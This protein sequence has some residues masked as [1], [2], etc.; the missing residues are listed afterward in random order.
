MSIIKSNYIYKIYWRQLYTN[1]ADVEK[2]CIYIGDESIHYNSNINNI[3]KIE[4]N[5]FPLIKWIT[6]QFFIFRERNLKNADEKKMSIFLEASKG[7]ISP[8][9]SSFVDAT[10][11][12][13]RDI[14]SP[15]KVN[16]LYIIVLWLHQW[17]K[18]H[19]K[20][21]TFEYKRNSRILSWFHIFFFTRNIIRT[22]E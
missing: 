19:A 4:Q 13:G 18:S 10:R 5:Y 2:V 14:G 20:R 22:F 21:K 16:S 6:P 1:V 11:L 8:R 9:Q 3:L 17:W 7:Q 15:V 12:P